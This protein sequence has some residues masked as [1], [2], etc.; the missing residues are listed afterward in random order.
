LLLPLTARKWR[1]ESAGKRLQLAVALLANVTGECWLI[2]PPDFKE[3]LICR[4]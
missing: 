4:S 2:L 1:E 3:L